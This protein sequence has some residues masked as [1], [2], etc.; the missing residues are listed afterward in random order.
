MHHTHMQTDAAVVVVVA[1]VERIRVCVR[2][3]EFSYACGAHFGRR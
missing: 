1:T 3:L 2:L